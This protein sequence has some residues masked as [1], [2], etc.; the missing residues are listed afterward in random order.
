[1]QKGR[2]A[3][4]WPM[5][6][7]HGRGPA[8]VRMSPD[9]G[10]PLFGSL[11]FALAQQDLLGAGKD[12]LILLVVHGD[13]ERDDAGRS[14]RRQRRDLQH[15]IKRVAGEYGFQKFRGLLG[16]GDQR[17]TDLMGEG[18]GAGGGEGEDLEAVGE[19]SGVAALTAIFD[20]VMDRMIVG[21]DR[22]KCGKMR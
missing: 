19:R 5:S 2:R 9:R 21:R 15:R 1:M 13:R 3:G 10:S 18:A 6:P 14:L 8:G 11:A 20:I 7:G 4:W 12:K 22:L 16:K 17:V